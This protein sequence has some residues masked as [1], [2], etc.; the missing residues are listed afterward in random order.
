MGWVSKMYCSLECVAMGII[1]KLSNH[2]PGEMEVLLVEF[3]CLIFK[4]W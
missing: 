1:H 2:T 4:E 3:L